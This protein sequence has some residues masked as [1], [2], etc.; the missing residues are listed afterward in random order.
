VKQLRIE[1]AGTL[2]VYLMVLAGFWY[3]GI[4]QNNS[5]A[6]L[7]FFFLISLGIVALLLGYRNIQ[8]IS[9]RAI[10]EGEGFADEPLHLRLAIENPGRRPLFGLMV[11]PLVEEQKGAFIPME[12]D[13][14]DPRDQTLQ[15]TSAALERGVYRLT[16]I[17]ITSIYPLGLIRWDRR[18]PV[19]GTLTIYPR[20]A[21]ELPLPLVEALGNE[22]NSAVRT[23]GDDFRGWRG[24][25]L[26]DSSRHIDWKAV[27]RGQ[28]WMVKEFEGES[29]CE[30]EI[31][32]AI[33]EIRDV[34]A[35]LSQIALWID[36]CKARGIA[37]GLTLPEKRFERK[38]GEAHGRETL[39]ALA[40][41]DASPGRMG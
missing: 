15:T 6:Y 35:R 3:A 28:P 16:A 30:V 24:Y 12:L 17:R 7:L 14:L 13:A 39:R 10:G 22:G 8:G 29:D 1:P 37:F 38:S 33:P 9:V 23:T 31:E 34:E 26:G 18:I 25:R 2:L 11:E 32:W 40:R 5:M 41:W 36:Q 4:S 27:A 20:R 21:G 19:E